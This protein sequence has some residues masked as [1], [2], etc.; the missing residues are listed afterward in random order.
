MFGTPEELKHKIAILEQHCHNLGRD[1]AEIRLSAC[2]T[3]VLRDSAAALSQVRPRTPVIVG[4]PD[5]LKHAVQEYVE[6]GVHEL[7][8]SPA[9]LG[10]AEGEREEYD[11]LMQGVVSEFQ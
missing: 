1:P 9:R 3:L 5:E 4:N 11:Q 10:S 2:A 8:I 6:A 7:V